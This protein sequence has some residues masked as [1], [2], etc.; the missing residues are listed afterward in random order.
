MSNCEKKEIEEKKEI[1]GV[2]KTK[3]YRGN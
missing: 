2:T 3:K 1:K